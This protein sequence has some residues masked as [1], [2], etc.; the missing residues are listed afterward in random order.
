MELGVRSVLLWSS[1][2]VRLAHPLSKTSGVAYSNPDRRHSPADAL[3]FTF[4]ASA[5]T[6]LPPAVIF[7]TL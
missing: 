7:K 2:F 1:E 3:P 6:L 5:P 4:K